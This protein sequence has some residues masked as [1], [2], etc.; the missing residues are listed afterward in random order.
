MTFAELVSPVYKILDLVHKK[1]LT[2]SKIVSV[3]LDKYAKCKDTD[4]NRSFSLSRSKKI[5][6]K[7]FS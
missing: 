6:Q 1:E 4:N 3:I 2:D 7:P 5:N